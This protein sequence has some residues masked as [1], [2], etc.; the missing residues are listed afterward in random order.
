MKKMIDRKFGFTRRCFEMRKG[1]AI[2]ILIAL[3]VLSALGTPSRGRASG[4]QL[5]FTTIDF[6][7]ATQTQLSSIN[8]TGQ[9]VGRYCVSCPNP[10]HGFL[11]N[12]GSFTTI[13]FPSASDTLANG[14]ND[15]GQIVGQY[16]AG[17]LRHG[18]LLDNGRF[19]AIVPQE[20]RK[21]RPTGLMGSV[22]L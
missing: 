17:G 14:I 13:D 9:I 15:A 11:L 21:P 2:S 18:Y 7:G 1:L 19:T 10:F 20:L 3:Y 5:T 22:R 6:P 12:Q 16:Y 8:N 4:T